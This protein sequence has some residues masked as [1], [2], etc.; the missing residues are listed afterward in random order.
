MADIRQNVNSGAKSLAFTSLFCLIIAFM[1]QSLWPSSIF[2]HLAISFGYG[3][4]AVF[5]AHL[6]NWYKPDLSFRQNH[7]LSLTSA[8]IL[9]T[10]NAYFWLSRYYNIGHIGEIK[11]VI[12][13]GFIFT[14]ACFFYFH[15]QE[16]KL[17]AQ[18]A[19]EVAKRKE[20]EQEKALILS[21]LKQLQSQIE[22]HFLFNTLANIN[23][24]I[25]HE[26][27]TAQ[28]ML[29]KLTDLLRGTLK[30]SRQQHTSLAAELEMVEAYLSIQQ[31][32]LGDRLTFKLTN[33]Y[34]DDI[35]LPPLI[36][37]PLVENAIQ[38]G[39]EPKPDG[40]EVQIDVIKQEQSLLIEVIDSGVGFGQPSNHVGHGV[41]LDNIRQR[42]TALFGN[43]ASLTITESPQ[44]G[45]AAKV[46]ITLSALATLKD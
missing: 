35:C 36:L 26:P 11:P 6:L 16:Q 34:V 10:L 9:G 39:I 42:L 24:L 15:T 25:I 5:T 45:V 29:S 20:S 17:L 37:Q 7:V 13:L 43:E 41:G 3:Y 19:L 1:T 18:K 4:S 30:S 46:K 33:R 27:R 44:G 21:Q 22:P 12:L 2:N 28:L 32:R 31:I 23:A 14:V 8:M 38:H 40:G